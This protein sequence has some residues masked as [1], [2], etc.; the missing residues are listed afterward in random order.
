MFPMGRRDDKSV[1]TTSF[2]PGA[3]LITL[4]GRKDLNNRNTCNSL[5]CIL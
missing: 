4:K 5:L 2:N 3:L 1:C